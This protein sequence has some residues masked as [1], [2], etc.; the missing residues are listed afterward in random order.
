MDHLLKAL[1][2]LYSKRDLSIDKRSILVDVLSAQYHEINQ[3]IPTNVNLLKNKEFLPLQQVINFVL[4]E[5]QFF[6]HKIIST[7]NISRNW[8][9]IPMFILYLF[10]GWRQ[11]IMILKKLVKHQFLA[12][13]LT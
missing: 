8:K 4:W 2:K 5:A 10:F 9:F 7:I 1:I 13:I 6:I 12:K 11:K 3:P